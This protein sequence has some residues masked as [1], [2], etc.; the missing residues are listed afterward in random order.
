MDLIAAHPTPGLTAPLKN[1]KK[2]WVDARPSINRP[3][4]RGLADEKLDNSFVLSTAE[5]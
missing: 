4:L 5:L 2:G 1:K 3:P